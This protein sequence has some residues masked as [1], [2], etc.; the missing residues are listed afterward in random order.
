MTKLKDYYAI[1]NV[2]RTA[3]QEEIKKAYRKRALE[4]HPDRNKGEDEE[5][6]QVGEAYRVLSD[7]L[8]RVRYDMQ[9]EIAQRMSQRMPFSV[10]NPLDEIIMQEILRHSRGG[11]FSVRRQHHAGNIDPF[12]REIIED[13]VVT[14]HRRRQHDV[15]DIDDLLREASKG[16]GRVVHHRIVINDEVVY[17]SRQAGEKKGLSA[18]YR[19]IRKVSIQPAVGD[20]KFAYSHGSSTVVVDGSGTAEQ[21]GAV[22]NLKGFA[23]DINMG[24]LIVD[25]EGLGANFYGSIAAAG[26]ISTLGGILDL[27]I[28]LPIVIKPEVVDGSIKVYGFVQTREGIRPKTSMNVLD[29]VL[30]MMVIDGN[31]KLRYTGQ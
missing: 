8:Q 4:T 16:S 1:L 22:L 11:G 10:S 20:V 30:N 17:D 3:T 15:R 6:K 14:V 21:V 13:A 19:G 9:L 28:P 26:R 2:E 29:D 5:F 18:T 24:P 31:I 7:T 27:E 25:I 12:I 23:G